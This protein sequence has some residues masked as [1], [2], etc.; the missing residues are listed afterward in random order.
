MACGGRKLKIA[1]GKI[2]VITAIAVQSNETTHHI[3]PR[4]RFRLETSWNFSPFVYS[5]SVHGGVSPQN[6]P[7]TPS[8]SLA[9]VADYPWPDL[10]AVRD[11][12]RM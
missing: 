3:F 12:R 1:R 8:P 7:W 9:L 5:S 6:N 11:K 4:N 2:R 10:R